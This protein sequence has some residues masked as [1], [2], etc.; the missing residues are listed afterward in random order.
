MLPDI[1]IMRLLIEFKAEVNV[2]S[3]LGKTLLHLA[4]VK[5]CPEAVGI[6]L[7]AGANPDLGNE[8]IK[9]SCL[10]NALTVEN[11]NFNIITRLL[12]SGATVK[13]ID[14]IKE[15]WIADQRIF[16]KLKNTKTG[17]H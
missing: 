15:E 12:Q 11:F 16:S 17:S 4:I 10:Y 2:M 1:G 7:Q 9:Y 8:S 14:K 3:K 5:E 6:L 13:H